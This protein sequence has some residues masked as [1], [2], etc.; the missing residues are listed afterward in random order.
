MDW[1]KAGLLSTVIHLS[2]NIKNNVEKDTTLLLFFLSI[3]S[4][5]PCDFLPN[6]TLSCIWVA[7]PGWSARKIDENYFL[8]FRLAINYAKPPFFIAYSRLCRLHCRNLAEGGCF[9]SWFHFTLCRYFLGLVTCRNLPR[10]G[11]RKTTLATQSRL[12]GFPYNSL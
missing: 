8:A 12:S 9:L 5:R 2:V 11:L 3:K 10:L 7:P 1:F 6:K 4:G